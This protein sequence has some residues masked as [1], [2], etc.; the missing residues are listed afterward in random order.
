MNF[1]V[2]ARV[3][4]WVPYI[5]LAYLSFFLW[6][7][8]TEHAG[9]RVWVATGAGLCAF[10][11][12]YFS[13]FNSRKSRSLIHLAGITALGMIFAPFNGGAANFFIYTASMVPFAVETEWTAALAIAGVVATA[14][15]EAWLLH[16]HNG[17]LFPA[18]FL[19]TFIGA[20]NVYFAQRIRHIEELRAAHAEVEQL[21]KVAER[22]RIARDLHDVLGHTL[23]LITF[24]S[25]LAGKLIDRDPLQAKLEIRDVEQTARQALADV[26]QAIGGYRSKGLAAEMKQAQAT[27]ETAGVK[28][29]FQ[30]SAIALPATQE[31]VLALALREAVT[32]VVRHAQARNCGVQFERVN[33]YWQLEIHD[34]GRGGPAMEGNG[35]RGMRERVEALGGNLHRDTS[36]GTRLT[37]QF[38]VTSAEETSGA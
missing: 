37:I 5:W 14:A 31:S 2:Q 1:R 15:L 13:F 30:S 23:S 36:R 35:L 16:I 38:P 29:Q 18:T 7:P 32:N 27:L 19:S 28:A 22:E 24:K 6:Q 11:F 25:E 9:W 17:F 20:A 3:P 33:G 8:V 12:F 34:D 21:A 26:R 10:L 4:R